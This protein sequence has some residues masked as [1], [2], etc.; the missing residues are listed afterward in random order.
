[1]QAAQGMDC[2]EEESDHSENSGTDQH[3]LIAAILTL[4]GRLIYHPYTF[5]QYK[6]GA[7]YR[8]MPPWEP[9]RQQ[10]KSYNL[11]SQP[12]WPSFDL[13]SYLKP[14]FIFLCHFTSPSVVLEG[15]PCCP[16]DFPK[17]IFNQANQ[18]LISKLLKISPTLSHD[19]IT[20]KRTDSCSLFYVYK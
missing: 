9:A 16:W 2:S 20:N 19:E 17:E 6:P 5:I 8:G 4:L 11:Q 15:A 1:M 7:S 12:L 10:N 3:V 13:G 14:L 18:Y